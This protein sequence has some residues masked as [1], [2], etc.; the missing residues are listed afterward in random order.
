LVCGARLDGKAIVGLSV[1][2][3][4]RRPRN[5]DNGSRVASTESSGEAYAGPSKEAVSHLRDAL[6]KGIGWQRALVEAM[7]LW[8]ASEEVVGGRHYR[9]LIQDE[10]FNWPLLGGRLL[11]EMS[12]TVTVDQQTLVSSI[13]LELP[14]S[15]VR[16]SF[17]VEK[18][19]A[20]LN[21]W[22]GVIVEQAIQ[23]AVDDEIR[24]ERA[25]RGLSLEYSLP[26]ELYVR[27]YDE[28]KDVLLAKYRNLGIGTNSEETT[29]FTYWLFKLRLEH[30]EK[31]RIASDTRKGLDWLTDHPKAIYT[32][33]QNQQ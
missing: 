18:Y 25:G 5:F 28:G 29:E 16:K 9:Y 33:T 6:G 15:V 21:Y 23:R 31:E 20:F 32:A 4:A 22:Y 13:L 7:G 14:R 12:S 27:I 24:K 26:N 30:S 1:M 19:R 17:G 11:Q 2:P 10:A 3:R 8:T